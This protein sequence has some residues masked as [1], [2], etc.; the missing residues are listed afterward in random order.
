MF[1]N[2]LI[3][4]GRGNEGHILP[5]FDRD[6]FAVFCGVIDGCVKSRGHV[7]RLPS[8]SRRLPFPVYATSRRGT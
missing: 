2:N 7:A 3:W 8:C 5:V 4:E 6:C 1:M